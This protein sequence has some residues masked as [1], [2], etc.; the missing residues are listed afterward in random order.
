V[1]V[2]DIVVNELGLRIVLEDKQ[3]DENFAF[4]RTLP[5]NFENLIYGLLFTSRIISSPSDILHLEVQNQLA[6]VRLAEIC[7]LHEKIV[8]L[9]PTARLVSGVCGPE[10]SMIGVWQAC[11]LPPVESEMKLKPEIIRKAIQGLNHQMTLFRQTGGTHGAGLADENGSLLYLSEDVG[12]HNA[13]DRVI[14]KALIQNHALSSSFLVSSGRL[15][16]DLVLKVA[17]ARIPL[18]A[19]ISA[20]ISSGVELAD[21]AG[22][23][24]IGFVR[25]SRMNVYTHP[26]RLYCT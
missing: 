16:A 20:A 21:A 13:I 14:G 17:V 19:S 8:Q 26:D 9:R 22:I 11:D 2:E 15:T 25:G 7:N 10:E 12:R 5:Q 3:G 6:R 1:T 18:I 4:I 23:T 24:L